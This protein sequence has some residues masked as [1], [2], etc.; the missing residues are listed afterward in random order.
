MDPFGAVHAE[1]GYLLSVRRV[2]KRNTEELGPAS[3]GL[4]PV[5]PDRSSDNPAI[6]CEEAEECWTGKHRRGPVAGEHFATR[7]QSGGRES[8]NSP[9]PCR[10]RERRDCDHQREERGST[11]CLLRRVSC[12]AIQI[13][14]PLIAQFRTSN[15]GRAPGCMRREQ[16]PLP[17]SMYNGHEATRTSIP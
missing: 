11:A 16:A 5:L 12:G 17:R 8:R 13:T 15:L 2:Q 14:C 7:P 3:E 4:L 6:V 9:G 10:R 1:S